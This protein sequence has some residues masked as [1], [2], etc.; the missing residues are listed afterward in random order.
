[1]GAGY[2]SVL[3]QS[4]TGS[5]KTRMALDMV[6]G[7]VRKGSIAMFAVPRTELLLQTMETLSG[8]DVPFSTIA[9]GY[10]YSPISPVHL[11]MTPT[12]ARR[13]DRVKPPKVLFV[14]ECHFGG[15]ELD[16]II[17]WAMDAGAR[18]V[19][20]SAT[21]MK[22]NGKGMGLWYQHMEEGLPVSELIRRG[23]LS[24]FR[25]FGPS[26]PDLSGVKVRDGEYVQSQ[27]D[28][29]M[30]QYKAISGDAV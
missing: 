4:A 13:L 6:M 28:A 17:T 1:M 19:G 3:M 5:G 14:D 23:R 18:I 10:S 24:Q 21:P 12:L 22:T 16:R 30:E 27:L 25:Y 26:A 20:L 29:Y 15:S 11:A 7:A 8:Y 9:P 2:Q